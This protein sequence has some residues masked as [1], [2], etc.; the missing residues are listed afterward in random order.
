MLVRVL[1]FLAALC[2]TAAA[3]ADD[4]D[5]SLVIDKYIQHFVVD[6]NG[7]YSMTVDNVKTIAE[8][9]AVQAHSQYYISYNKTLDEVSD[10]RAYTHKPDGRRIDVGP[11]QIMDQQEAASADA[12]MFQD[13]RMKIIV[14]PDVAVGDQLVVHYVLRRHTPLFPGHF[15]DLSS[16]QFYLNRQFHLVYDMPASMPLHAD[17]VGFVPVPAISRPG[18]TVYQWQYVNGPNERIESESVS[19]LDYGKRLAVSTFPDYAAFARAYHARARARAAISPAIARLAAELTAG[20]DTPRAKVLALSDWVR[21]QIR[22]V[23]VY[24]GPGGVVPHAASLVLENRYGDC[25]DHAILLEALLRAAGI[26]SSAA[27]VNSGNAYRL[28]ATPTLGIFN[29]VITYVPSL[30]LYLDSTAE[31]IAA[32]YLPS[33]VMGK[34]VLLAASGTVARTP[35][36]QRERNRTVTSFGLYK[37]GRSTFKVAR[38]TEGA[39]AE[40]YRQAVRDTKQSDRELFVQ[41]MLQGLGQKGNGVFDPGKVDGNGDI[42]R[43][44][45]AGTSDNFA[46]LPG[47]T[48]LATT[49]NFWGGMGDTLFALGQEKERKQDFVCPAIDTEDETG[50]VL[51]KG[52]RILALPRPLSLRDANFF[53]ES[54]YE[55]RANTV[56]IKRRVTFRNAGIVCTPE[57]YRRMAPLVERMIRDLKSQIIVTAS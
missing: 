5:P 56:T 29:H 12:P 3:R 48:G 25:K 14:F 57:D 31:S 16:S 13:T 54:R 42:Y 17:A 28:P 21:R 10:V 26:D 1:A 36:S 35:S 8:Q 47:P 15:E 22:Y 6:D 23:G 18:R 30:D 39:I 9:R 37:D 50:Y 4:T 45:I 7:S 41:Q 40:S 52:V 20:L 55:R 2:L 46:N 53:Y 24:V 32:G 19:Y 27:L 34:P 44:D 43:L 38:I 51:P 49:F 11:A 33:S